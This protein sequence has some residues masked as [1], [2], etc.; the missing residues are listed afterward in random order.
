MKHLSLDIEGLEE[1]ETLNKV[2]HQVKGIVGVKDAY[3]NTI[4]TQL[5]V[6]YDERTSEAEI[7][8]HLQ[9]NGYKVK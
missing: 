3:L 5:K 2:R 8:N 9:N 6:S 1:K 4:E 7:I